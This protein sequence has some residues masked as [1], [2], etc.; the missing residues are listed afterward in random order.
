MKITSFEISKLSGISGPTSI[1]IGR[2]GK[3]LKHFGYEAETK[4]SEL[5]EEKQHTE[6][7]YFRRFKMLLHRE[8]VTAI[9]CF[10][11]IILVK[12]ETLY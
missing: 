4:Y 1:L 5:A 8:G 12:V 11:V 6:W 2:D 9:W 3:H 10:F 7:Y